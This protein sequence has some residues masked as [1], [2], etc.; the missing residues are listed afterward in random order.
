MQLVAGPVQSKTIVPLFNDKYIFGKY[1]EITDDTTTIPLYYNK[2]FLLNMMHHVHVQGKKIAVAVPSVGWVYIIV[3]L[4]SNKKV[5]AIDSKSTLNVNTIDFSKYDVVVYTSAISAGHSIDIRNHF[6][7]VYGVISNVNKNG[8]WVTPPIGEMIQMIGRVRHPISDQIFLTL[9]TLSRGNTINKK[10]Y[11]PFI[12][13]TPYSVMMYNKKMFTNNLS[14]LSYVEFEYLTNKWITEKAFPKSTV[15]KD[16]DLSLTNIIRTINNSK[17][18]IKHAKQ[19]VKETEIWAK[20]R[21]PNLFYRLGCNSNGK[22]RFECIPQCKDEFNE[23]EK[24]TG[25]KLEY[26]AIAEDQY[27]ITGIVE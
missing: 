17:E 18:Q 24:L 9:D 21:R 5:L 3:K 1:I 14:Q 6:Y 27:V 15:N 25:L 10:Y 23:E 20:L 12:S 19:A 13:N 22:I 8:E 7:C 4:F 2:A 16:F 11:C 26:D